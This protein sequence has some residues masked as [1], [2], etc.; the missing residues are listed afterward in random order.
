[1]GKLLDKKTL[2]LM[3]ECSDYDDYDD[4]EEDFDDEDEDELDD[5]F[6]DA[7]EVPTEFERRPEEVSIMVVPSA[8]GDEN[9]VDYDDVEKLADYEECTLKEAVSMIC[10]LYEGM[11]LSNTRLVLDEKSSIVKDL[12][13]KS[14]AQKKKIKKKVDDI[15][16][17]GIKIATGKKDKSA[18]KCP[19]C[20]RK[21]CI[22]D[23]ECKK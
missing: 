4:D 15:K 9:Y 8:T 5:Y 10:G 13:D 20:G 6:E 2:L 21:S 14:K 3:E 12:K 7:D 17:Q 18:K 16:A 22:C 1:M 11:N 19:K 23:E